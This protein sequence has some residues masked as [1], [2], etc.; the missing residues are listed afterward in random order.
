MMK[1]GI[2]KS[3]L[4]FVVL[5]LMLLSIH[6]RAD[7]Q[8]AA[9][10]LLYTDQE[11]DNLLASIAL[12]PDPLL[13]QILPASTYP[14]EIADAY[15]WQASGGAMSEI[16][17]QNWDD[18]VK[19]IA[20]YPDILKMM[21]DYGDWTADIGDAFLNQPEDVTASI[22]RLRWDAREAGNLESNSQQTIVIDGDY[23]EIIPA[24]PQ[25]VY[26]PYYDPSVVYAQGWDSN[27]A[28]FI[29]FGSGLIIGG[30]LTMDFDWGRHCV[31]YHGWNRPGWVNHARPYVHVRNE[32]IN[33][34][35]PYINSNWKHIAS[36]GN[37]ESFRMAHPGVSTGAGMKSRMAEIRGRFVKT[38]PAM[39]LPK[40]GSSRQAASSQDIKKQ[41]VVTI[42]NI[43]QRTGRQVPG[44]SGGTGQ[45]SPAREIVRSPKTPS[46][47]FG[48][49]RGASEAMGQ[50]LRGQ[51]SRQS[52]ERVPS[53]AAPPA[54][55][56]SAP[57]RSGG[58][59]GS[60]P[61]RGGGFGGNASPGR[62]ESSGDKS[63]R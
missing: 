43:D 13:A 61:E 52:S 53:A 41:P 42:T 12:Y 55:Q 44:F 19:A 58:F 51:A 7:D 15:D 29:T 62:G 47:T 60:V 49:Y 46:V 63:H 36:H 25:Y 50:S 48:G 31:I 2:K 5:F 3:L 11:L 59:R 17:M 57:D 39:S 30:W 27:E 54:V 22:Q 4:I 21:A 1:N 32:T 14:Q 18:S 20:H 38:A 40:S 33:K 56:R 23:I 24:Q 6:V 45:T 28:P 35:K 37:P 8:Y 26:V 10:P 9:S 34:I 16:D